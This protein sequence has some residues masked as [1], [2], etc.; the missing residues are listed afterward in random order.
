MTET[1]MLEEP[2]LFISLNS[3]E[4]GTGTLCRE[5]RLRHTCTSTSSTRGS[6]VQLHDIQCLP[7]NS[8]VFTDPR[9]S[10]K[11][12]VLGLNVGDMKARKW[13]LVVILLLYIGLI[14]SFCLNISLLLRTYPKQN[15]SLQQTNKPVIKSKGNLI[16]FLPL[17]V[18]IKLQL[19]VPFFLTFS[20]KPSINKC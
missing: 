19:F 9:T 4:G 5:G 16:P 3:R 1:R 12:R 15:D 17:I 13:Y 7:Y 14:T 11:S 6:S 10:L 2:D 8:Q 18:S 20:L